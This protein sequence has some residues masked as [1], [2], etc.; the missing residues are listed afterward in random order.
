MMDLR[1]D[2]LDPVSFS[3]RGSCRV[4]PG[5]NIGRQLAGCYLVSGAFGASDRAMVV[6]WFIISQKLMVVG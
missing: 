1:T 2:F 3:A 6:W 5:S 4:D